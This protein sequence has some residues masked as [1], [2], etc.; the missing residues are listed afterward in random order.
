[1]KIMEEVLAEPAN[2]SVFKN[3]VNPMRVGLMLIRAVTEVHETFGMSQNTTDII[4][5]DLTQKLRDALEMYNEPE[6]L[7]HMVEMTDYEGNDLFWYL[8]EYDLYNILDCRIM[9]RVI[10]MKWKGK[11]ELNAE[12]LD[13]STSYTL[14]NDKFELFANDRVFGEIKY[15]MFTLNKSS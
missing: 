12:M 4:L 1:M 3:N 9:D 6:E 10:E 15:A 5:E 14:F 11:F 2:N 13:Y 7:M 8:D